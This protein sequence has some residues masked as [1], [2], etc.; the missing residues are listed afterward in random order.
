MGRGMM[1]MGTFSPHMMMGG[2]PQDGGKMAGSTGNPGNGVHHP[3]RNSGEGR[4]GKSGENPYFWPQL[5]R[6]DQDAT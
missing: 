4:P 5:G 6:C 2:W 3:K 1:I